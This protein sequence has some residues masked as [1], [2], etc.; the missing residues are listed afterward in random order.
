MSNHRFNLGM[1]HVA[2]FLHVLYCS[3][4][5]NCSEWPTSNRHNMGCA[6]MLWSG[7]SLQLLTAFL[8]SSRLY[9]LFVLVSLHTVLV[10]RWRQ[11]GRTILQCRRNATANIWEVI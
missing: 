6:C 1:Q 3:A 2:A 9:D 8:L 5:V 11:A 10:V 4:V 7:D